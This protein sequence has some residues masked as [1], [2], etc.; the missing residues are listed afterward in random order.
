MMR[1][2]SEMLGGPLSGVDMLSRICVV[3]STNFMNW[4]QDHGGSFACP[5]RCQSPIAG[6]NQLGPWRWDWL[7]ALRPAVRHTPATAEAR[8]V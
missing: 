7:T 6:M 8:G 4:N 2:L 3:T 5:H 1:P